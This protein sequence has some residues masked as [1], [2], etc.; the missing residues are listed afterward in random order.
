MRFA[1]KFG[2][3]ASESALLAQIAGEPATAHVSSCPVC[4]ARL[5]ALGAW[6]DDTAAEA[7]AMADAVFTPERLAE[8]KSEILRRLEA[9]GRS[10]RVIAFPAGTPAPALQSTRQV[11]RWAAAAAVAGMMVGLASGRLLD[12]NGSAQPSTAGL[13]PRSEPAPRPQTIASAA[14]DLDEAALLDAAYDRISL[15]SLRTIDDMTP[16]AREATLASLPR[17]RR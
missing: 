6:V 14:D 10:A 15:D 5:A 9:A 3:H 17:S 16:R 8:Q 1:E 13:Q 12:L 7:G 2:R 11:L 4:Q